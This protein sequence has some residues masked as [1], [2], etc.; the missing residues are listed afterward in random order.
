MASPANTVRVRLNQQQLELIDRTLAKGVAAMLVLKPAVWE[1][2]L[3]PGVALGMAAGLLV[4]LF[5]VF[6]PRPAH[7]A[8]EHEA[9]PAPAREAKG[10]AKGAAQGREGLR[11]ALRGVR[12]A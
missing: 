12:R 1:T 7:V 4:L 6:L 2:W 8:L 3:K 11:A 5:V 9:L 10:A